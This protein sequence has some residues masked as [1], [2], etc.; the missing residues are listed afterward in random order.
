MVRLDPDWCELF[1]ACVADCCHDVPILL[2]C[3]Q[4]DHYIILIKN[5]ANTLF[6]LIHVIIKFVHN[7][8]TRITV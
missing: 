2:L 5:C 4:L 3:S 1:V 7:V 6:L 8:L